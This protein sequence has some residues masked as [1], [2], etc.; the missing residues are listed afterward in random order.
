MVVQV[1]GNLSKSS[2]QAQKAG[3]KSKSKPRRNKTN[4]FHKKALKVLKGQTDNFDVINPNAAGIDVGSE[5]MFV[6]V[7]VDRDPKSVRMFRSYTEDLHSL[8]DW[9]IQCNIT[10][11][12]I[13]SKP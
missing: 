1:Q 4:R 2:P 8:A 5:E 13:E 9:L 10:T 7:P 6:A 3:N 11:V 12:A